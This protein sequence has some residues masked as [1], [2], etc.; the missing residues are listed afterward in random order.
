[1]DFQTLEKAK[2]LERKITEYQSE[3]SEL[4]QTVKDKSPCVKITVD[5]HK[6]YRII[7]EFNNSIITFIVNS[8]TERI[9]L[10][11]QEFDDL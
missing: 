1:M 8:Y 6:D 9:N 10:L 7:E 3:L 11:Q 2:I 5:S 4:D